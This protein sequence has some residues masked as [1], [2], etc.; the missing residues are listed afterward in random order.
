MGVNVDALRAAALQPGVK[1]PSGYF[2]KLCKED[3]RKRFPGI[4]DNI[5]GLALAGSNLQAVFFF[6]VAA[7]SMALKLRLFRLY[8]ISMFG[9]LAAFFSYFFLVQE[10]TQIRSGLA[11]G[12]LYLS[13]FAFAEGR[14]K[15]FW[16]YG[17]AA[18]MFHVSCVLFIAAP[19]LFSPGNK[20]RWAI[21]VLVATS[22]AAVSALAG[23]M[24]LF[25]LHLH[26]PKT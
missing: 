7:A 19:L 15:H 13:W 12:F 26:S 21:S 8:G 16:L 5:L 11:I 10:V 4:N 17:V 23:P 9:C 25:A 14:K 24:T 2:Q 18:A 20:P 1:N 3:L 22:L 6:C